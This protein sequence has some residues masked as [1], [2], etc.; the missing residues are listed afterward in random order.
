MQAAI[1]RSLRRSRERASE[2]S[3]SE[4]AGCSFTRRPLDIL[5][6]HVSEQLATCGFDLLLRECAVLFLEGRHDLGESV[7]GEL[8]PDGFG[9]VAGQPA[10]AGSGAELADQLGRH[11]DGD[12][13]GSPRSG[14]LH[15][16][17]AGQAL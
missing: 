5:G 15:A 12:V 2:S 4:R 17:S 9:D 3:T 16:P 14:R 8:V 6:V 10:A 11:G 7:H 13:S 1:P